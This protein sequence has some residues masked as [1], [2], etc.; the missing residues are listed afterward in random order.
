[1]SR[2]AQPPFFLSFSLAASG[3]RRLPA[4]D[5][6]LWKRGQG[7]GRLQKPEPTLVDPMIT[8]WWARLEWSACGN[9]LKSA[10]G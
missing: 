6:H 2:E 4:D 3:G 8:N 7:A 10:D 5:L 9:G 1:M